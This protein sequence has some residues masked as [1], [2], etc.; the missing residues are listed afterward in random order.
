[1]HVVPRSRGGTH[2][3]DNVVAACRT[4]NVRKRDRLLHETTMHLRRHP[5]APRGPSWSIMATGSV[6]GDWRPYLGEG[7]PA[8][9]AAVAAGCPLAIEWQVHDVE[10]TTLM[11]GSRQTMEVVDRSAVATADVDVV[12][13]RSGGGAVL[14]EPGNALWIDAFVPR[15]D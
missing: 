13:R 6:P 15:D 2:T 4:C 10:R 9:E 1:D 11:L 14:L 3:W 5:S 7:W 8:Q 12:I